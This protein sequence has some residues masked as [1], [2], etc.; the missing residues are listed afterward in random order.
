M[1]P[2]QTGATLELASRL[3][4]AP[5][6]L[7]PDVLHFLSWCKMDIED[8]GMWASQNEDPRV[9]NVGSMQGSVAVIPITGSLMRGSFFSDYDVI[10]DAFDAAVA[11]S[12]VSSILLDV[13][14]PGGEVRGMFDLA[15]R[16][17]SAR[18]TKPIWAHANDQMTSAAYALASSADQVISSA[19]GSIGS[20][21]V[22]AMHVDQS[23]AAEKA[24]LK[25]TEIAS[26][27]NKTALTPNRP[28][29]NLGKSVLEKVVSD[30]ANQF[31]DLVSRNR[32]LPVDAI[33]SQEAGVFTASEAVELGLADRVAS[34]STVLHELTNPAATSEASFSVAAE[35]PVP[36]T[37][38]RAPEEGSHM[39]DASEETTQVIE[40][41]PVAAVEEVEVQASAPEEVEVSETDLAHAEGRMA[42]VNEAR[43][44]VELCTLAGVAA[45]ASAFIAEGANVE[46]VRAQLLEAKAVQ[47]ESEGI[48]NQVDALTSASSPQAD[49]NPAAIYQARREIG[50]RK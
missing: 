16:I 1:N 8:I 42:G 20:I 9:A 49:I 19:T 41:A 2:E 45:Q 44:I 33:R 39:A 10:G 3:Y 29:S 37:N 48:N 46:Q 35:S 24:G 40:E 17:H 12:S 27:E 18:G 15:E 28:L 30:A 26:G 25:F 23:G 13:D 14:S 34:R 4:N 43:E 47:G 36:T 11:D 5:L 7:H 32:E 38:G 31:F 22:V 50:R 6:A 21:G